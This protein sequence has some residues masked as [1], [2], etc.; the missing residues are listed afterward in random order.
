MS[1]ALGMEYCGAGFVGWQRQSGQRTVQHCLEEALSR[2][3]DRPV[4]V[5]CAG[6]T[7]AGVHA[8]YQVAHFSPAVER[9][10]DA[11][12]LGTNTHLPADV[13]VLWVHPVTEDFHA[14]YSALRRCYRYLLLNRR[15][16]PGLWSGR[17]GWEA[18]PLD[19]IAMRRGAAFLQ[20]EHDF[21]SYRASG[22]QAKSPWRCL[23]RLEVYRAEDF[24]IFEAEAN[25]FLQHMVRNMVGVL[26]Q[27]GLG[28]RPSQ[29]AREVLLARD[30]RCAGIN[31]AAAGLYLVDVRYPE[32]FQLPRPRY[33]P[34]FALP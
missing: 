6:R 7:D 27:I 18:R 33:F 17:L 29:W 34:G 13:K 16:A 32:H 22:C 9:L 10:S 1:L 23:Y 28:R 24:L 14:R 15:T 26:L 20:G 5:Q 25:A 31:A 11:W 3:A 8:S 19:V 4:Q 21:S 2:V 12:V 30:R